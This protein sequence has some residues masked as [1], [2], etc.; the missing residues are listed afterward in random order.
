M[1]AP[2]PAPA[3]SA[4]SAAASAAFS[5]YQHAEYMTEEIGILDIPHDVLV[6][7]ITRWIK[8]GKDLDDMFS[9]YLIRAFNTLVDK[10]SNTLVS[11][12]DKIVIQNHIKEKM[13]SS[14]NLLRVTQ[15][16]AGYT[17]FCRELFGTEDGVQSR[18]VLEGISPTAQCAVAITTEQPNCYLCGHILKVKQV[19]ATNAASAAAAATNMINNSNSDDEVGLNDTVLASSECE[20]VLPVSDALFHLALVNNT[21]RFRSLPPIAVDILQ[22][23]YKWAHKCCNQA[24]SNTQLIKQEGGIYVVYEVGLVK[25]FQDIAYHLGKHQ[26]DC[27]AIFGSTLD[28]NTPQKTA[29][30]EE[31]C[32]TIRTNNLFH[33]LGIINQ[34]IANLQ[35]TRGISL[36]NANII[37][38]YVSYARFLS[39]LP[40]NK[41]VQAFV[42]NIASKPQMDEELLRQLEEQLEAERVALLEKRRIEREQRHRQ[43]T[44]NQL[45][46]IAEEKRKIATQQFNKFLRYM[47]RANTVLDPRYEEEAVAAEKAAAIAVAAAATN[48]MVNTYTKKRKA[49]N[50]NI[51]AN[52]PMPSAATV[53]SATNDK[54]NGGH[55]DIYDKYIQSV[56]GMEYRYILLLSYYP[57]FLV[58]HRAHDIPIEKYMTLSNLKEAY[59]YYGLEDAWVD[60]LSRSSSPAPPLSRRRTIYTR[61]INR[62]PS[63]RRIRNIPTTPKRSGGSMKFDTRKRKYKMHTRKRK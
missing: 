24:K 18:K 45:S 57:I 61:R 39:R 13:V 9:G 8:T 38:E 20:H 3:A 60:K 2:A 56:P 40:Y 44:A 37:Y 26:Y 27:R 63:P 42:T 55:I 16:T 59:D 6:D 11:T 62:T 52:V 23:E 31:R 32:N 50:A 29:Y 12:T 28:T 15:R 5:P 49:P 14:I 30:I 51:F 17:R 4:A 48:A 10:M 35:A 41:V 22:K 34:N 54:M 21:K 43:K 19:A 7:N 46:K 25:I 47:T 33:I 36:V 53:P 58:K 1:A